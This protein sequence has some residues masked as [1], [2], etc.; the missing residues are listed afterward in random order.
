MGKSVSVEDQ[1]ALLRNQLRARRADLNPGERL[2]HSQKI[3][4]KLCRHPCFS[5]AVALLA[6]VALP[7]EVETRPF[8]EQ[9][10]KAKKRVFVPRVDPNQKR[11]WMMELL[12]LKH[13]KPGSY[14][15]LE[16]PFDSKRAGNPRDLELAVVP[17]LGFDPEGGRLGRGAGYF[18]RFLKEAVKAYKIGLAFECQI[19]EKIPCGPDDV[20][21]DEVLIG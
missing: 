12:D 2:A 21:M 16:P 15:I 4:D 8:L 6:Y 18:D 1:K 11:I 9:A 13:L 3:V 5:K 7:P 10:L 14:G 17:G 20:K 19:V